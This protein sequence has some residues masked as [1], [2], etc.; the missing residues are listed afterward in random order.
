MKYMKIL[1]MLFLKICIDSVTKFFNK[2]AAT[3]YGL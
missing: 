1:L 3:P 2:G